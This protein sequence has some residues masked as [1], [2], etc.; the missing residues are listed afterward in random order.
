MMYKIRSL[1][2]AQKVA[3]HLGDTIQSVRLGSNMIIDIGDIVVVS[4]T[5]AISL[6]GSLVEELREQFKVES[7]ELDCDGYANYVSR[8][9]EHEFSDLDKTAH[10]MSFVT[11]K[12]VNSYQ[13]LVEL[14]DEI[15]KF[16]TVLEVHGRY[17]VDSPEKFK[18][19][20]VSYNKN[21]EI[22]SSTVLFTRGDTVIANVSASE[23][24]ALKKV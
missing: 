7:S 2:D 5:K 12:V 14:V 15:I 8:E 3:S 11:T 18:I 20:A 22:K 23:G 1:E 17:N 9:N 13:N 4:G 19:C 10:T 21:E 24:V 6:E 16:P